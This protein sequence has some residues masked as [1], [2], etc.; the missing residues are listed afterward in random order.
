[1]WYSATSSRFE[2]PTVVNLSST[3]ITLSWLKPGY[4]KIFTPDLIISGYFCA[5]ARWLNAWSDSP[6]RITVTSTPRF[7]ALISAF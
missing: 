5:A 6:G 3:T 1:M 2:L 7:A 4:S